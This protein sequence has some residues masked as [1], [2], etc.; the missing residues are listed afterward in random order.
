MLAGLRPPLVRYTA[1]PPRRRAAVSRSAPSRRA[2]HG[3][4]S[5]CMQHVWCKGHGRAAGRWRGLSDGQAGRRALRVLQGRKPRDAR[6]RT[7]AACAAAIQRELRCARSASPK[8]I[9]HQRL[10][11]HCRAVATGAR[12]P[13]RRHLGRRRTMG[14]LHVGR[15]LR[16]RRFGTG[17]RTAHAPRAP[18]GPRGGGQCCQARVRAR[19]HLRRVCVHVCVCVF[20]DTTQALRRTTWRLSASCRPLSW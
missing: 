1:T 6:Q 2:L 19:P 11:R 3:F 17:R 10:Q 5:V 12:R 8:H 13:R 7:A 4:G 16:R 15:T 9:R 14:R 20:G 18:L